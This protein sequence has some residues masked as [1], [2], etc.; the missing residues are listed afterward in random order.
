MTSD[1]VDSYGADAPA[2]VP[3]DARALQV[4]LV[5]DGEID[6]AA[7]GPEGT[8]AARAHHAVARAELPL[9]ALA[10]SK[11]DPAIPTVMVE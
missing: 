2:S 9:Q 1:H 5:I 8:R 7:E 6:T 4:R 10:L 3:S 11:S